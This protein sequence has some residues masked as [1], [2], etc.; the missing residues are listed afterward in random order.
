M[1]PLLCGNLC[2]APGA[3]YHARFWG[4]PRGFLRLLAIVLLLGW[5]L[6]HRFTKMGG[7]DDVEGF[8]H[9]LSGWRG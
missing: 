4:E 2:D 9:G 8:G 5:F 6:G 1:P 7:G 3:R